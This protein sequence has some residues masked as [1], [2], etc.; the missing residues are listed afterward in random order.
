MIDIIDHKNL[1]KSKITCHSGGADG[2]DKIFEDISIQYGIKVKAYSYKTKYH[3]SPNKVEISEEDYKEG[4]EKIKKANIYLN[5][6]GINKFMNLLA[7]NWAQVKYSSQVIA[8]GTIV[9]PGEKDPKGYTCGSKGQ[10]LSGGTAYAVQMAIDESKPVYVFNQ[11]LG[12]WYEWNY[13]T[14]R[15]S[16][17]ATPKLFFEDFAGIGTREINSYGIKA[18]EEFFKKNF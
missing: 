9:N 8:I 6:W 16:K 10:S 18:I 1:D 12:F 4:I 11:K 2:S 5:R 17:C 14:F 15:F 3:N 13:S 7:R